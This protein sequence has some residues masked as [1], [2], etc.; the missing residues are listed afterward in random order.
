MANI[1]STVS[2]RKKKGE[3]TGRA[4]KIER[5]FWQFFTTS[6]MENCTT[7]LNYSATG[8]I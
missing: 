4:L 6:A 2:K 8:E 5:E 3:A 7:I 1:S